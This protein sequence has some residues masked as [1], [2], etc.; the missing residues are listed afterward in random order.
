MG[1]MF[2]HKRSSNHRASRQIL[3]AWLRRGRRGNGEHLRPVIS[4]IKTT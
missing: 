4:A 1:Q 3:L 2:K